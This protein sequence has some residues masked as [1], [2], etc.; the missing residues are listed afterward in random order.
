MRRPRRRLRGR[1]LP[2][3][4]HRTPDGH[5][6]AVRTH[7]SLTTATLARH[8]RRSGR[9]AAGRVRYRGARRDRQGRPP[10]TALFPVHGGEYLFLPGGRRENGETPQECARREL[11]EEAGITDAAWRPL[12][13]YALSVN[14]TA[15][16]SFFEARQLTLGPQELTLSES[17]FKLSWWPVQ[18]AIAAALDGRFLL[19]GG[20]LALLLVDRHD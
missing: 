18:D 7:G 16:V 5:E 12:G 13:S 17:D 14:S 2:R 4:G 8:G 9:S 20:P 10:L 19:Q 6:R 11:R 15:R 1:R 3:T